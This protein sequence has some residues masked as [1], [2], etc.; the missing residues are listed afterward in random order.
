M[1]TV[2]TALG[3][4]ATAELGPTQAGVKDDQIEQMLAGNPRAIFEARTRGHGG[5]HA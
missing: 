1:T 4:V 5:R 3:P 2:E